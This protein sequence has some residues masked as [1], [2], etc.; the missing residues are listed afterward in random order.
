MG[1]WNPQ[2]REAKPGDESLIHEAHMRSIREVCIK[3]HGEEEIHGWGGSSRP[4]QTQ[5][6]AGYPVRYYPMEF[7]I[8]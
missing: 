4:F 6:I 3:D 8:A 7:S 1:R 5:E 2:I